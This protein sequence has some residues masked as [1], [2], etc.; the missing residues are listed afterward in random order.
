MALAAASLYIAR[1]SHQTASA[2]VEEARNANAIA[3]HQYHD[4]MDRAP[5]AERRRISAEIMSWFGNATLAAARGQ[6][7]LKTPFVREAFGPMDQSVSAYSDPALSKFGSYTRQFSRSL[8]P[9]RSRPLRRPR[10]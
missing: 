10:R 7:W 8:T 9:Q 1:Q 3:Q 2:A 5:R 4:E 6:D